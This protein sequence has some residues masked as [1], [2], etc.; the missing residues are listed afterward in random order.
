MIRKTLQELDVELKA[1]T[2]RQGEP[3]GEITFYAA[4][5]SNIG[6]KI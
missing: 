2:D 1:L 5:F 6:S 4:V 3:T